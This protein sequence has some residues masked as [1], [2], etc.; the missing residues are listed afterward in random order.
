MYVR[1][2]KRLFDT[3]VA[4]LAI[5]ILF[6]LLAIVAIAVFLEDRHSPFFL[7]ERPGKAGER[8]RLIK[9]RSMPVGTE[10]VASADAV[11][12]R[13]TRAGRV[14]RRTNMDELPQLLNIVM[15]HM[16]FVGPRPPLP[17]QTDLL[18]LRRQNGSDQCRPGLTGLAQISG[19]DGM[20]V[21]AKAEL[22]GR[23]ATDIGFLTDLA[24]IGRTLPYLLRRPPVY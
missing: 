6:P 16:S 12:L 14:L 11:A 23:Y 13:V 21:S 20:S 18:S 8:F 3:T 10:D 17:S 15:G 9:F 2:G 7:Q 22:D 5:V 24:I 1:F 19:Y 4:L